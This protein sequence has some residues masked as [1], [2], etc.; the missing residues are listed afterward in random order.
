MK[1]L[2]L[3]TTALVTFSSVAAQAQS[4]PFP[5][6]LGTVWTPAQWNAAWEDKMDYPPSGAIPL[7]AWTTATRPTS[8]APGWTG[9]N[10]TLSLIEYWNG[11]TWTTTGGGGGGSGTVNSGT[12]NQL[13]Y[14][15]STGTAVS[16]LATASNGVL[17]TSADGVPSISSTLPTAVQANIS[18]SNVTTGTFPPGVLPLGSSANFGALK[19]DGTTITATAGVISSVVSGSGTVNSGTANQL[20]YYSGS[21]TAVSGLATANNGILVTSAGGV[22][23]IS[24][25]LPTAVQGSVSASNITTGTFTPGVLPH[26]TS[27]AFGAVKV[28]G[29]TITASGGV[30]SAVGGTGCT[31]GAAYCVGWYNVVSYGADP[32][33]VADST[34]AIN[35]ATAAATAAGGGVVYFPAG[36]Y[37]VSALTTLGNGVTLQGDGKENTTIWSSAT[38]GNLIAA[39]GQYDLVKDLT[40]ETKA[41][42]TSGAA[43][44]LSGA[45]NQVVNVTLTSDATSGHS[46]YDGIVVDD[47]GGIAGDTWDTTLEK[48]QQ[49]YVSDW[50]VILGSSAG[51]SI[52][53]MQGGD[54]VITSVGDIKLTNSNSWNILS[55][56]FV[57][58]NNGVYIVPGAGQSVYSIYF[59]EDVFSAFSSGWGIYIAPTVGGTFGTSGTVYE[60]KGAQVQIDGTTS[61]GG[62]GI[63]GAVVGGVQL[64]GTVKFDSFTI[65]GGAGTGNGFSDVGA[66][67][68]SLTNSSVTGWNYGVSTSSGTSNFTFIG[69]YIGP[70]QGQPGNTNGMSIA[71]ST[72]HFVVDGN[73]FNG[74]TST[75]LTNAST[76][77]AAVICN[78]SGSAISVGCG[79]GAGGVTS[80]GAGNGGILVSPTVGATLVY[81]QGVLSNNAGSGISIAGTTGNSTITNTGV[82]SLAGTSSQ[83]AVSG[84]TG[85]VTL[86]LPSS[87][88]VPNITASTSLTIPNSTYLKS[89]DG[90][91]LILGL[92][93]STY[94]GASSQT[95]LW[96][97]ASSAVTPGVDGTVSLGGTGFRWANVYAVQ[98][99]ANTNVAGVSCSGLPSA[100]FASTNGIVTHC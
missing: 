88:S 27:A 10:A 54:P 16:G 52:Y 22:P 9:Y 17:V 14:Y 21:G 94:V 55:S 29:T 80:V 95:N 31:A 36:L 11:S 99:Y 84:S 2:L 63:N 76:G 40:L 49:Y 34:S 62:V 61:N 81:N 98:Y 57:D 59:N 48:V 92:S 15:G 78:N 6:S 82:T 41:V 64:V 60:I 13:S 25:T 85:A 100:S 37:Q 30:I 43:V 39:T 8:P 65:S 50:K 51:G 71:A 97:L 26:A 72:D 67:D 70:T 18:A 91:E 33:G 66:Q 35:T 47:V 96:L 23:S 75:G 12:A 83:V 1:K 87:I 58:T 73:T 24:S 53:D 5:I 79:G 45:H 93:G 69:N 56:G 77:A 20:S 74:N 89:A 28:D 19:V 46:W 7:F 44:H 86:S 42:R 4:V 3:A 68:V 38:T 90:T 32:S